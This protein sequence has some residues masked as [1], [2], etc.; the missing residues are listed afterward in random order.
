MRKEQAAAKTGR[1]ALAVGLA[2]L[3]AAC[4]PALANSDDLA[5]D[6]STTVPEATT[7]TTIPTETTNPTDTTTTV[8]SA[9]P[10]TIPDTTPGPD[11]QPSDSEVL[12]YLLDPQDS[13]CA[14]VTPVVRRVQS[15]RVLS[16]AIEALLAGPTAEERQAGYDSWFSEEVGWGLAS[17][18]VTDGVARIDFT[19]DSPR[20]PN[21]STSCGSM[22][23]LAQL[24]S[25]ATQFPTVDRAVYSLGGDIRAF[26]HWLERDVPKV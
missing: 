14:A 12:V 23:L 4:G 11:D 1:T 15:P 9:P 18:S 3:L 21:A 24:D 8:P 25:T 19:E 13:D 20:I 2:F 17:V 7:S 22:A 5:S 16:G 26:Y 10:T 6:S